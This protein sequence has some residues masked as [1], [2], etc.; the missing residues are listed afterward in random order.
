M[1]RQAQAAGWA[2]ARITLAASAALLIASP[3]ARADSARPRAWVDRTVV[4]FTAPELGGTK[5]PRF[6]TE[7]ELAFA[8]RLEGIADPDEDGAL[9]SERHV[10][11]ALDRHIAETL[12]SEL[13]G[14]LKLNATDIAKR[15]RAAQNRLEGRLGREAIAAAARAEDI[16]DAEISA[17]YLRQARASLYLDRMLMPLLEPTDEELRAALRSGTTPFSTQEH[18]NKPFR[19]IKPALKRWLVAQRIAQTTANF[20]QQARVRVQVVVLPRARADHKS[21]R[22]PR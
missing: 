10:R 21:E 12:L 11:A 19:E 16:S 6:V 1:K 17:M 4:R 9:Y 20:Y 18:A 14:T 8:T 13:A 15:A 5:A 7:R 2:R 22:A 3:H